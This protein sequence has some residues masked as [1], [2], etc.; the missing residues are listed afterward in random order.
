M[1]GG[2]QLTRFVPNRWRKCHL[3]TAF[4]IDVNIVKILGIRI[5]LGSL[6]SK[7]YQDWLKEG[8]LIT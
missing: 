2:G 7:I 6:A 5:S 8:S 1:L 3:V 4:Y